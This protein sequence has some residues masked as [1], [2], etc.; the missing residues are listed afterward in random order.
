MSKVK[1]QHFVPRFYLENFTDSKGNIHAFDII[2]CQSFATATDNIAHEKYFYDY[3]P[4]DEFVGIDQTVEKALAKFEAESAK[5]LRKLIIG[6]KANNIVEFSTVDYMQLADYIITQQ[7]RT[8][9]NRI[10]GNQLAIETERR[11]RSKGA[12]VEFINEFGFA[13]DEYDPQFQ[14]IY[15]LLNSGVLGDIEDMCNRY[16]IFWSNMTKHNFYTSDHP[17][18]GH[19]HTD[20]DWQGYEIYFPI[21]P[22]YSVSILI[23]SQF[24]HKALNHQKIVR[25]EDSEHVKFYNSLVLTQCNRQIYSAEN[26]FRLA[27]KII[28]ETP[29]LTDPNR[30]RIARMD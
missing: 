4:L 21:T 22:R 27:K 15:G 12:S 30:Q 3:N 1:K 6:L 10:K 9:E 18:V 14:Q 5:T 20:K 17:V 7:K 24:Q 16:W 25:L 8:P 23:K 29:A 26:D 28:K 11:L 13:A 2:T 19:L